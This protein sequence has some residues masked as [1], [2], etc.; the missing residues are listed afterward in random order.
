MSLTALQWRMLPEY[1]M[2]ISGT[3][4]T[5]S[6]SIVNDRISILNGI[7]TS[8]TSSIYHDGSPRIAGSNGWLF[9]KSGSNLEKDGGTN[10]VYGYPP[11]I[12]RISQS[13]IFAAGPTGS[14]PHSSIKLMNS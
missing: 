14:I 11:T 2:P 8:F 9:F 12:T 5:V 7:Y 13:I 10:V 3:V 1:F 6:Q 4:G